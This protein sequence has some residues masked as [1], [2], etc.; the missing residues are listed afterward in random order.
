MK[1]NETD[2]AIIKHLWDGRKPFSRIAEEMGLTT[3]TVRNRVK[4]ML[5]S[6]AIQIS[7]LVNPFVLEDHSSAVVGFRFSPGLI[8]SGVEQ[9]G[10]LQGVVFSALVSGRYDAIAFL[11]FNEKFTYE[12]FLEQEVPKLEGL[13]EMET[14]NVLD[15]I[16]YQLRYALKA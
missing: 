7:C 14:F 12:D 13:M 3:V 11:L 2:F 16:N 4:R 5:G 8:N 9:V 6:N 1:I 10:K 15:G